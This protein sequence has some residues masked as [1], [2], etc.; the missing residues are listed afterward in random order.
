MRVY[1]PLLEF[2]Q[3]AFRE[4]RCIIPAS[5]FFEWK[6]QGKNKQPYFISAR[7]GMPLSFAGIW[8]S[9]TAVDTGEFIES[10]TIITTTPN[11]LMKTIHD[12][13]PVIL[14]TDAWDT[15][16]SP[17]PQSD[18]ALLPLLKLLDTDLMQAWPVSPAIGKV[19]NQGEELIKPMQ[20]A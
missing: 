8:G 20:S 5:G 15:W 14:P 16:L 17:F 3:Y 1:V 18:E 13:M 9:W 4:R 7:D 2:N 10:C 11:A 6:T 19:A 12:R